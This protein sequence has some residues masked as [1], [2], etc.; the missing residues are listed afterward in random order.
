MY[1]E[2]AIYD[3]A[4]ESLRIYGRKSK[5]S[6]NEKVIYECSAMIYSIRQEYKEDT[7]SYSVTKSIYEIEKEM[8]FRLQKKIRQDE[9]Y[10]EEATKACK[11]A[12]TYIELMVKPRINLS[13]LAC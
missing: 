4:K 8:I 10:L 7:R 9:E 5:K 2:E 3:L 6:V 11:D 12:L 13:S 1:Q